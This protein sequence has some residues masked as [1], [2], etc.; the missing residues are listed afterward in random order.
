MGVVRRAY[1][2]RFE[3]LNGRNSVGNLSICVRVLPNEY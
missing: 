1:R 3:K 2:I